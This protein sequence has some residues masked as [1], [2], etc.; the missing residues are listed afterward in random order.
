MILEKNYEQIF[1][2]VLLDLFEKEFDE[3]PILKEELIDIL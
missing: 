1:E 2:D 3:Y